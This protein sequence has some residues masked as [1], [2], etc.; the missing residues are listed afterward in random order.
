MLGHLRKLRRDARDARIGRG[1]MDFR[2]APYALGDTLTWITN[3]NV[4]A[5]EQS[6]DGIEVNLLTL[7]QAPSSRFQPH[8]NSGNYFQVVDELLPAFACSERIRSI[9]V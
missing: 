1:F 8:I 5:E 2:A 7:P 6:L 3:L 9:R 4:L